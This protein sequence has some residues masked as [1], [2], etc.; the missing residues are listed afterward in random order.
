[1]YAPQPP[2]LVV[3]ETFLPDLVTAVVS[4]LVDQFPFR[5]VTKF[6][7]E[8]SRTERNFFGTPRSK[9]IFES[10]PQ[11]YIEEFSRNLLEFASASHKY[12]CAFLHLLGFGTLDSL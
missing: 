2:I 7:A 9:I 3:C 11:S 10:Y 1:M 12:P 4:F 5:M 6:L 8:P